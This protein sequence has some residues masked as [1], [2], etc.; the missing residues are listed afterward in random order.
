[1][2]GPENGT[3]GSSFRVSVLFKGLPIVS[4]SLA[5]CCQHWSE[6]PD[7]SAKGLACIFPPYSF[8][9]RHPE[10]RIILAFR[11]C[12]RSSP[13]AIWTVV[14]LQ[15]PHS[16]CLLWKNVYSGPLPFKKL[17]CLLFWCWVVRIL[18]IFWI[19]L[20]IRYFI[21]EYLPL[22]SQWPFYFVV[23]FFLCTILFSWM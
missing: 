8:Q 18:C 5:F 17:G 10:G 3:F 22:F 11:N 6:C 19:L 16:I 7:G 15:S 21:P 12:P 23:S 14:S 1:M 4:S 9:H 13:M 20:L 2:S